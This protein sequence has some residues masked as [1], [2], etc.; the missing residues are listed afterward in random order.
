MR[1]RRLLAPTLGVISA[2]I[3]LL[4]WLLSSPPGSS[5]DDGYHLSSIWCAR[6]F[7]PDRCIDGSPPG[8]SQ[9]TGV[10]I[11]PAATQAVTCVATR[12]SEAASCIY[13]A[14]SLSPERLATTT[15][16]NVRGERARLYYTAMSVFV[17]DDYPRA[18]FLIRF[19]NVLVAL[20]ALTATIVVAPPPVRGAFSATWV[21]TA[22][23]L[24]LFLVTSVN[25]SA[26]GLV[27]L[28][29][30]W[31]N[32]L[33]LL[34]T[35]TPTR[36]G[37]AG[38]LM[39]LGVVMALGARTEALGHLVFAGL[40]LLLLSL[41]GRSLSLDRWRSLGGAARTRIIV[42]LLAGVAVLVLLVRR[43][44]PI[45]YLGSILSSPRAGYDRLVLGGRSQPLIPLLTEVPLLWTGSFGDRFG[46]GWLD[47]AMPIIVYVMVLTSFAAL[48]GLGLQNARP[49]RIAA[50][51]TMV[52]A[53]FA[54]PTYTLL[55]I[56]APVGE[57]YQPRHYLPSIMLLLGIALVGSRGRPSLHLGRAGVIG[58]TIPLSI[59]HAVA[60][61]T[62]IRRYTQ[63]LRMD[64]RLDLNETI[65]WWW[66]HGPSPMTTWVIGSL[67]FAMTSIVALGLLRPASEA[68][69]VAGRWQTQ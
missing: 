36:R 57:S 59:A 1:L 58:L 18:F 51:T 7:D 15:G 66:A 52:V 28:T 2:F 8:S 4:A 62:N 69:S 47:T 17:S 14:L 54:L 11:V 65:G 60:L 26:W 37:A 40:A 64:I 38:A 5:P 43:V 25:S 34:R 63:G 9:P 6:G 22:V 41:E 33:T 23:P 42:A 49:A 39:V 68:R 32:A 50:L 3:V 45:G 67:A 24:G 13:D 44:A 29:L 19:A 31:G 12:S 53:L 16:G 27:G 35:T 21:V 30:V 56:G 61:H 10:V 55:S 48:L 46:L 20:L